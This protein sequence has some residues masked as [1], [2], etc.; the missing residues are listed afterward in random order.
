[1]QLLRSLAFNVV[2]YVW[3]LV[4]G[5]AY[6]PWAIVSPEGARA[7][8]DAY[9]RSVLWLLA[10]MTGLRTEVRGVPPTGGALVA[11]KHQSFLDILLIWDSMPRPFFIMKSLLRFAPILGQYALRLGCIPVHRGKRTEA[12]KRML[13]EVRSG[14]RQNGQ[15][16]IYP[17]GT[18]VAPGARLPYKVGTFAL[19]EQLGQPCVPV[20]TNVGVF[21]PK[22]GALRRAGLGVVEF[23]EPILPGLGRAT[24]MATMERRIEEASNRLMAE[25]GFPVALAPQTTADALADTTRTIARD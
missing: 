13:A 4:V 2:M 6:L 23:L 14:K 8:C 9:A 18:R 19:Y 17:Q 11:G 10:R 20:A 3:M 25:A 7:G 12:I 22:R 24:F 1:M 16:L 5:L 21:W 15:L